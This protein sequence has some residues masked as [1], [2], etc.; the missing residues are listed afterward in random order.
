MTRTVPR[1]GGVVFGAAVL[2]ALSMH[3]VKASTKA[4]E[5]EWTAPDGCPTAAFIEAEV[6][7]IV[8]R[9]WGELGVSWQRAVAA[10]PW[11]G[12]GLRFQ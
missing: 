10:R 11:L 7:R 5:L 4:F 12:L 9:S 3:D 8:G 1:A 6:T 2:L